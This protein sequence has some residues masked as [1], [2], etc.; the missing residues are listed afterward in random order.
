MALGSLRRRLSRAGSVREAVLAHECPRLGE[1]HVDDARSDG[2]M[3]TP[4][5]KSSPLVV[6][7]VAADE[8]DPGAGQADHD[9][10]GVALFVR[11][12]RTTSP[13]VRVRSSSPLTSRTLPTT[14][15]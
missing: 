10:A 2:A 14:S 9:D 12:N 8:P 1:E 5:T 15:S 6:A 13:A 3:R 7:A 11:S 4:S